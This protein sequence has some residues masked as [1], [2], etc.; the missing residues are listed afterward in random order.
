VE[1]IREGK[2]ARQRTLLNLGRHFE[3]PREQWGAFVQR[4]ELGLKLKA[5]YRI[6]DQLLKHKGALEGFLYAQERT[7]F[8]FQEVITLYDLTNTYFEGTLQGDANAQLGKSKEKGSDCPLET[9]ALVLDASGFAKRSEIFAGNISEPK[10]LAQILG[11]LPSGYAD[12]APTVVL[13]A[14]IATEENIAWPVQSGYRYL[15]V[16]RKRHR[17]FDPDQASMIK[18]EG[19]LTIRAQRL[20]NADTGEVELYCHS[21]QRENK[22]RGIAERG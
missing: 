1:S 22:E 18:E 21:S 12:T 20:V 3:V 6:G 9:L 11:K 5:L 16:S 10:T 13:D 17:Q 8:D 2:Q 7:L 14:G 4:I 19:D 15:V